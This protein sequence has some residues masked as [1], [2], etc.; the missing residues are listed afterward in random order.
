MGIIVNQFQS[1]KA[2]TFTKSEN[3]SLLR[4]QEP[5]LK[6]SFSS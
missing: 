3:L 1:E 6:R 4:R 2:E 5:S